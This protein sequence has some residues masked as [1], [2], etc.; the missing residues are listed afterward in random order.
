MDFELTQVLSPGF[1]TFLYICT[2]SSHNKIGAVG[3]TNF[4]VI[5]AEAKN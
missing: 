4:Y 3:E 5:L 1:M 2:L